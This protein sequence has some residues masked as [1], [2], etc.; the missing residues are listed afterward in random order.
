MPKPIIFIPQSERLLNLSKP[1]HDLDSSRATTNMV[2]WL[3][4]VIIGE[5]AALI[6]GGSLLQMKNLWDS[7]A[8]I[9]TSPGG[10]NDD[11]E[12]EGITVF[13]RNLS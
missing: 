7:L 6:S 5:N 11:G 4:S 2:S 3:I 12:R 13:F 1:Y 10:A 9:A 8:L